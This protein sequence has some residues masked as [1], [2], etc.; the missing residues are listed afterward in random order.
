MAHESS[1]ISQVITWFQNRRAKLKRDMEELKK[2]VE[3]VN[4]IT[5]HK[6][7]LENVNDMNLLRKK[8]VSAH[9]HDNSFSPTK[10]WEQFRSKSFSFTLRLRN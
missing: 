8:S 3:S 6:S 2:D 10:W 5:T 9:G 4:I 7:F 1:F